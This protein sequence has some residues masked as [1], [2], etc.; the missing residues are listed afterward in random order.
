MFESGFEPGMDRLSDLHRIPESWIQ[1]YEIKGVIRFAVN[2][3]DSL[4]TTEE[5]HPGSPA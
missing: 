2:I 3:G 5:S 1:V 4:D